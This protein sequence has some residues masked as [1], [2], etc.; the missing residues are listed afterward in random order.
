MDE[1]IVSEL[2][3]VLSEYQLLDIRLANVIEY[4]RQSMTPDK[5]IYKAAEELLK[6]PPEKV[7]YSP[8]KKREG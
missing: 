3:I 8:F 5:A 1:K 2:E 4:I 6:P 7:D